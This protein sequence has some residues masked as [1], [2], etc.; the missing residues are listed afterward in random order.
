MT[1]RF[2]IPGNPIAQG[3]P[4]FARKGNFVSAYDPAKS[5]NWKAYVAW[6]VKK[7][8][9]GCLTA[10]LEGPLM[11]TLTFYFLKPKSLSK[12]VQHHIKKPD[13][14]NLLAGVEDAME[15]IVYRNDSQICSILVSKHYGDKAETIIEIKEI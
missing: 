13:C 3:R 8:L 9:E 15:G 14:K 1:Y 2:V 6:H 11:L 10:P 12:K 5:R 4:K 7:Q